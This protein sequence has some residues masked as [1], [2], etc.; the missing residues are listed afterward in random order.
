MHVRGKVGEFVGK[1]NIGEGNLCRVVFLGL[2]SFSR[3][4]IPGDKLC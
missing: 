4:F 1:V 3:G 2:G